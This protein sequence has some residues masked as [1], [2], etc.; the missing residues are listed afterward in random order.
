MGLTPR[1]SV[2]VGVGVEI[3][4]WP[5]RSLG[6]ASAALAPD[7][8]VVGPPLVA[9]DPL[10]PPHAAATASPAP[11]ARNERRLTGWA[12]PRTYPAL[13]ALRFRVDGRDVEVSDDG[14]SL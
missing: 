2:G 14:A 6:C 10:L 4:F 7:A 5:T 11:A 12:T 9:L 1:W 8:V 3:I 13:V